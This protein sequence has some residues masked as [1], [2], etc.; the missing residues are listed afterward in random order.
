MYVYKY[1][2]VFVSLS[3][4]LNSLQSIRQYVIFL[5]MDIEYYTEPKLKVATFHF[6]FSD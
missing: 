4:G 6:H 1:K 5:S 2:D 3:I